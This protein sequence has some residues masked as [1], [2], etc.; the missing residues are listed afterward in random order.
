MN[1]KNRVKAISQLLGILVC[2]TLLQAACAQPEGSEGSSISDNV[3]YG[4]G[5]PISDNGNGISE[6]AKAHTITPNYRSV[7]LTSGNNEKFNVSFKNEGNETLTI[8]PKVVTL[9]GGNNI[10]ENWISI[11]PT[12]ATVESG[13][14]QDFTVEVDTPKD[15]GSAYYQTAIAFTDDLLPNSPDYVNAMKL[16]I[17]VQVS[18]KIELQSTYLSDTVVA[19]KEYEYRVKIKN[20]ADED[21]TIDPKVTGSSNLIVYSYGTSSNT[22]VSSDDS[23]VISA[24]SIIKAGEIASMTIKVPVLENATGSYNGNIDMNVDGKSNDGSNPQLNL[25]LRA[26]QQ[27]T[28]PYVKTFNTKNKAPITIEVSTDYYSDQTMGMRISPEVEEPSFKIKMKLNSRSVRVSPSKIVQ[29]NNINLGSS[30]YPA[31]ALDDDTMY[32]N[33][34]KHYVE[35]FTVP[36]AVGKWELSILPENTETFGYTIT[37][38]KSK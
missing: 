4:N 36:G 15:A 30:Y 1:K 29:G 10:V 18:P 25:Y 33:T 6:T 11:S 7:Y 19:E 24:P 28:V 23:I 5:T 14:V 26:I 2:L 3:T 16:D 8:T 32:Q 20:V 37:S 21:V 9:Y 22:V 31:W 34:N 17:S 35:T 12:S 38:G 27:P 13:A